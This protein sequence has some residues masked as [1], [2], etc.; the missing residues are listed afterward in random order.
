ML[1]DGGGKIRATG[2]VAL[3]GDALAEGDRLFLRGSG[4]SAAAS[5]PIRSGPFRADLPPGEYKVRITAAWA[6]GGI[7]PPEM[8]DMPV[9]ESLVPAEYNSATALRAT[10]NAGMGPLSFQLHTRPRGGRK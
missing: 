9:L 1:V 2:P 10:V 4:G 5:G 7:A 6:V 3:G 8:G